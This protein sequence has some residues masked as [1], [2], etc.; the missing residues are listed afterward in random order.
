MEEKKRK[1]YWHR[2]EYLELLKK[3]RPETYNKIMLV[4]SGALL[5]EGT[6]VRSPNSHEKKELPKY[7]E[8]KIN[9]GKS[10]K[11]YLAEKGLKLKGSMFG[12]I[13]YQSK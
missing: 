8:E 6:S 2:E 10:Y 4:E 7:A 9:K 11:E 5:K 13:G 3:T 12:Q 1:K